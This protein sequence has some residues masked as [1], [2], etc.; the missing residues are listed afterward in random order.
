MLTLSQATFEL[1]G[2]CSQ[3]RI[4]ELQDLWLE[5]VD[6]RH[7]VKVPESPRGTDMRSLTTSF[8]TNTF[9]NACC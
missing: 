8:V 2:L 9:N 5:S 3:V 1:D 4:A 6:L 7:L